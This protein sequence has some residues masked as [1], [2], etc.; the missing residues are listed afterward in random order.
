M[1]LSKRIFDTLV[2]LA[3]LVIILPLMLVISLLAALIPAHE[4]AQKEPA[5]A[6]HFV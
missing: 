2:T 4:A 1:R 6:L 3:G 5:E